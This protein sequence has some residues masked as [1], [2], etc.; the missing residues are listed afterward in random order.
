MICA[1]G[2]TNLSLVPYGRDVVIRRR[3]WYGPFHC[4]MYEVRAIAEEE[5]YPILDLFFEVDEVWNYIVAKGHRVR[6]GKSLLL[7]TVEAYRRCR[8]VEDMLKK[9]E[10]TLTAGKGNGTEDC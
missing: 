9:F 4:D 10:T 5:P 8:E 2:T 7:M 1:M 6:N 3:Y